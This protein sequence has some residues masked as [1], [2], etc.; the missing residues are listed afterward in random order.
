MLTFDFRLTMENVWGAAL[1]FA[2]CS[3]YTKS[4]DPHHPHDP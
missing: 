4:G 1:S 3:L 2:K